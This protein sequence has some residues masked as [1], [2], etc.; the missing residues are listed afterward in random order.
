M[1][2][3]TEEQ[4]VAQAP[5][6]V[7]LGGKEFEVKP[8]VIRD[9]R[10]WRKKAAPFQAML[11]RYAGITSDNLEEFEKTLAEIMGSRIDETIDLFFEYAKDLNREEIEGIATDKEIVTAFNE[12]T[13]V[14]FPFGE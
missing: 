9:S 8:L 11:A 2:K 13:K 12:V 4:I 10:A 1:K 5:I 6:I 3:R 14:A 7:V